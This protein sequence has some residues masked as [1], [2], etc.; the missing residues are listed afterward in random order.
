M[1]RRN[2]YMVDHASLLLACSRGIPGGTMNT[3]LYAMREKIPV[4][5]IEID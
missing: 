3:M 2:R 5:T 1:M 4:I